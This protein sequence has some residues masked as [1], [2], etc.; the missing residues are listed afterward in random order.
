MKGK[1][2]PTACL[3]IFSFS[4]D[5][6]M[7]TVVNFICSKISLELFI[8]VKH[9]WIWIQKSNIGVTLKCEPVSC[10]SASSE[11]MSLQVAS[12]RVAS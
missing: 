2:K 11:P 10:E 7:S 3:K 4:V 8:S 5:D 12:L 6:I 1:M 9:K